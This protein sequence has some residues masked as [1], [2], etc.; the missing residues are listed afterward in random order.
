MKVLVT[1]SCLTLCDTMA[2]SLPAV[3]VHQILQARRLEWVA[4]PFFR[5]SSQSQESNPGLLDCRQ[6]FSQLFVV[7]GVDQSL[8][9]I[10]LCNPMNCNKPGFAVLHYLP[11]F[12]QTQ[13]HWASIQSNHLILCHPLLLPCS[14]FPSIRVFSMSQFFAS[15]GQ[16][17]GASASAS[18]SILPMNI[19]GWFPLGSTG[20]ISL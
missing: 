11:E 3:F 10:W 12:A 8:S 14:V 9:H 4:I 18:A 13:V 15:G 6:V 1:Q 20:L 5:I 17:I 16:S 19:Q 2:W 7:M